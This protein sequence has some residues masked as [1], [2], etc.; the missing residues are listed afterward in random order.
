[1]MRAHQRLVAHYQA[2]L[3]QDMAAIWEEQKDDFPDEGFAIAVQEIR[4]ALNLTRRAAESELNNAIDFWERLPHVG[5]LLKLGRID[6]RRAKVFAHET[7][8]LPEHIAQVVVEQTSSDAHRM[9]G[10]QLRALLRW[11]CVTA[12]PEHAHRAYTQAV[13][14]RRVVAEP[15]A[16][17]TARLTGLNLPPDRVE[18]A[19]NFVNA[20]A[21]SLRLAGEDRTM[22]QLRADVL[23]D[24]L[25]G[26][27]HKESA[28]GQGMV[29]IHV[30]LAT[31]A[32]LGEEPGELGGFGPVIADIARQV[33]REQEESEWRFAVTDPQ[34][35]EVVRE[36]ITRR[37]PT[38]RLRRAVERRDPRCVFP[39]CRM[40]A[41]Q[42]DL[43][44]ITP[45]ADRHQ[46]DEEILAPECRHDH[47]IRHLA[48]WKYE[49]L[50]DGDYLW[51]SPLGLRYTTSG[52]RPP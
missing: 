7:G 31:L 40:S 51:T 52:R 12:D 45:W 2:K 34:T 33:A 13:E 3:Y 43:D 27:P 24:L 49:R 46:T 21:K 10:A 50:P 39:G 28:S 8:A 4:A 11:Y 16:D 41:R 25:A 47:V 18:A 36:G 14:E 9:N 35:G 38:A 37:R 6:I 17:G 15:E 42:S 48:G 44:H 1:M 20:L 23:L 5:D 19:M 32:G 22:D 26:H 30:D 29:D